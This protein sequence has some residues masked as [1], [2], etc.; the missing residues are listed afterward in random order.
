LR[1]DHID[2]LRDPHQYF[3]RLQRLVERNAPPGS[4]AFYVIAE[5]ILAEGE[6]LPRFADVAGTTGYEW[7]NAISRLL[8]DDSDLAVLERT[9]H[10]ASGDARAFSSILIEAKRRVIAN[11]LVS[12]FT[13]L[14]RLLSRIA[15]KSR[16][17]REGKGNAGCRTRSRPR[18]SCPRRQHVG[19]N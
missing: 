16:G 8:L 14:T 19:R 13:V 5:K 6:R 11:I 9:W 3:R 18:A 1:L 15:E 2:G 4:A 10:R 7:L 17:G 12:E